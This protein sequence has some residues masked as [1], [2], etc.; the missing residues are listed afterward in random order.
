MALWKKMALP[1]PPF[2]KKEIRSPSTKGPEEM[3]K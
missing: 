3:E 2:S 1:P